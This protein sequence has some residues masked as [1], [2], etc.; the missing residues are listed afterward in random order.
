METLRQRFERLR[1]DVV[2]EYEKNMKS[3]TYKD[4]EIGMLIV[5]HVDLFMLGARY[6]VEEKRND[7]S[8]YCKRYNCGIRSEH[9]MCDWIVN[10]KTYPSIFYIK[11]GETLDVWRKK[12]E[13]E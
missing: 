2:V 5:P 1:K 8:F 10:E 6:L 4:L 11:E 9:I 7:G 13:K 3:I 12:F